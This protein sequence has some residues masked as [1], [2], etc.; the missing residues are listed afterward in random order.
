M[1]LDRLKDA[2]AAAVDSCVTPDLFLAMHRARVIA[3]SG[4]LLSVDAIPED[5][6]LPTM[7]AI[8]LV[9]VGGLKAQI[10]IGQGAP[11]AFVL[12]GWSGGDPSKPFALPFGGASTKLVL[13]ADQVFLGAEPGAEPGVK[14][15]TLQ[16]F[17]TEL[18]AALVSHVHPGVTTGPGSSAPSPLLA[19]LAA[20][21]I[22]TE[23]TQVE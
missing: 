19:T 16:S 13:A 14:G 8:P 10:A 23:K 17:L 6:R 2:F 5:P 9:V 11:D 22:T 20:P 18:T 3:Q 21:T 12:I 4:D 15:A 1:D 7:G